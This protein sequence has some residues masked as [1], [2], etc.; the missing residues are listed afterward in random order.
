M[1]DDFVEWMNQIA[2]GRPQEGDSSPATCEEAQKDTE[3][4]KPQEKS[5][6]TQRKAMLNEYRKHNSTEQE[7]NRLLELANDLQT[8]ITAG[9][10]RAEDPCTLLLDVATIVEKMTRWEDSTLEA[11][12]KA[13]Y[14]MGLGELKQLDEVIAQEKKDLRKLKKL[15]KQEE[16]FAAQVAGLK[17][18]VRRKEERIKMLE[19]LEKEPKAEEPEE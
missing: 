11:K 2:Q 13:V 8:A 16:E 12:V 18:V 1:N 19:A 9:L 14:G 4:P 17:D 5:T 10:D 15:Q 7:L 3:E 6:E